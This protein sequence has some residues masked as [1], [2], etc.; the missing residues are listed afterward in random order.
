MLACKRSS[1]GTKAASQRWG[2]LAHLCN[3]ASLSSDSTNEGGGSVLRRR[4]CRP[5]S[6]PLL[7]CT[8]LG[9]AAW[10]SC[11]ARGLLPLLAGLLLLLTGLLLLLLSSIDRLSAPAAGGTRCGGKAGV[12]C[13]QVV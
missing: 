12:M 13:L 4:P 7:P 1:G 11:A 9:E 3:A 10:C 2:C 8:C 6:P 5:A